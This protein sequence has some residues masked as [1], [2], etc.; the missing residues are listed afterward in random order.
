MF[1]FN[2]LHDDNDNRQVWVRVKLPNWFKPLLTRSSRVIQYE[3]CLP[4]STLYDWIKDVKIPVKVWYH[5]LGST[6]FKLEKIYEYFCL[7]KS[8]NSVRLPSTVSKNIY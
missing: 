1:D 8:K 5:L 7:G 4:K 2:E 3:Y 6:E